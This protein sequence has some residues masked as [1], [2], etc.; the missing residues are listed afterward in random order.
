MAVSGI[1]DYVQIQLQKNQTNSMDSIAL[2]SQ[3]LVERIKSERKETAVDLTRPDYVR[4]SGERG[5]LMAYKA[6]VAD[7]L[8]AMTKAKGA[9]E[10]A[11]SKLNTIL[12]KAQAT[13][14]T[15]DPDERA[16]LA[17]EVN[18]ALDF[19]NSKV[20]DAGVKIGYQTVNLVG[21]VRA[22]DYKT[23]P[24]YIH[25]GPKGGR[26]MVQGAYMG[27][28]YHIEDADGYNW[29][30]NEV[31]NV[32][33]Q[34]DSDSNPTGNTVSADNLTIDSF[35]H[36]TGAISL[37]GGAITGT[38]VSGGLGVL[39]S[40]LYNDF[41]SDTDIENA[42]DDILSGIDYVSQKGSFI[43]AQAVVMRN[44]DRTIGERV[45]NLNK[46]IDSITREELD[47]NAARNKAASLK[48]SLVVNNINLLAQHNT[49]IV[50]NLLDMTQGLARAPG[51]FGS[52]GY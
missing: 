7:E 12:A 41:A 51:V 47:D 29:T 35:D 23:D 44:A 40:E 21:D 16:A 30:L 10:W 24:L 39:N 25:T 9:I 14:G 20:N 22:P 46:E 18:E 1:G 6:K 38:V 52:M 31:D 15:S 19:I 50:Q 48:A 28:S 37:G 4:A 13:L 42:I 49:S 27:S 32:Y 33:V 34:R 26:E 43:K 3:K 45:S 17:Q 5:R 8:S 2:I 11:S 36:D